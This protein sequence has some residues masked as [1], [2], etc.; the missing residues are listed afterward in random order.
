[1]L[2][3]IGGVSAGLSWLPKYTSSSCLRVAL[4]ENSLVFPAEVGGT[5]WTD[6]DRF[7]I[8]KNTQ[9]QLLLNRFVLLGALRK[10]EVAKLPSIQYEQKY[11]DPVGWLLKRLSVDFPGNAEIMRV[12]ITRDDP[13]EAAILVAA[14]VDSYITEVVNVERDLKRQR[15]SELDRIYTEKE[16]ELRSKR[17]DLKQLAEQLGTSDTD[18]L[19]LKQR[20]ALEELTIY[21]QELARMQFEVRHLR[22]ELAAQQALLKNVDTAEIPSSEVEMLV[23]SDPVARQLFTELDGKK[24][25]DVY[26][27]SVLPTAAK[28]RYADRVSNE[29]KTLEEQ[30]NTRLA[31]L[32][33]D[34]RQNKRSLIE[35]EIEKLKT[36]VAVYTQQENTVAE[37]VQKL[38]TA[39]ERFGNSSIDIEMMRTDIKRSERV[40]DYLAAEREKLQIE[41]R[42]PSRVTLLQR[43]E[44]PEKPDDEPFPIVSMALCAVGAIGVI[45]LLAWTWRRRKSV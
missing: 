9:Q 16:T 26:T 35:T 14:V 32:R 43:A 44:E 37:E 36:S 8:Y 23:M 6:R 18:T 30:Y 10:P 19:T 38:R 11:G 40:L 31:K 3:I 29:I 39:V 33:E 2:C 41:A 4:Q 20:L 21:R 1:L 24:M 15:L 17:I 25:D 7:E 13:R 45:G 12:S 28:N 27:N 42:A 5:G 22:G 34:V